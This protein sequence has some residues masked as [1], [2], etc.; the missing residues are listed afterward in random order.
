MVRENR[1]KNINFPIG[2]LTSST[3]GIV[4]VYSEQPINGKVEK[5]TWQGGNHTATGSVEIR[6]SGAVSELLF[7]L[8]SGTS[9]GCV[10]TNNIWYPRAQ[11]TNTT[12]PL[13]VAATSGGIWTEHI[14]N[15][16]I[17]IIGSGL[18]NG[19][20]GLGLTVYYI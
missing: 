12:A 18:G 6:I 1:I 17:N 11:V 16:T 10:E 7:S 9:Q 2:S 4:D 15:S 8:T 19:K 3:G 20:S 5:I 14:T 13:G